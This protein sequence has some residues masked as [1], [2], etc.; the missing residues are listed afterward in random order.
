MIIIIANGI[1]ILIYSYSIFSLS[2]QVLYYILLQLKVEDSTK[3]FVSIRHDD[4]V[5]KND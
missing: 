5:L 4:I 2:R 1:I 3:P